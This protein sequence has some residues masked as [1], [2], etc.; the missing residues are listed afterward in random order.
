MI[1]HFQT[2]S[3]AAV[4]AAGLRAATHP[5][6][7]GPGWKVFLNTRDDMERTV[8]YIE[9]NPRA[10]RLPDQ[11]WEFVTPYDGWVPFQRDT[12]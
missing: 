9:K 10:S 5:V 11:R 2:K 1:E 7:G 12:P 6:W 8:G 3:R 4:I